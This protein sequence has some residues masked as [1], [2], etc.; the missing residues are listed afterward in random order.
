MQ[1]RRA[2]FD[3]TTSGCLGGHGGDRLRS[4]PLR[5]RATRTRGRL[6]RVG[7]RLSDQA[8][9]LTRGRDGAIYREFTTLDHARPGL[10]T[11]T[12]VP[13]LPLTG[14]ARCDMR[15]AARRSELRRRRNREG[16][17][18]DRSVYLPRGS[19]ICGSWS[20]SDRPDTERSLA[21]GGAPLHPPCRTTCNPQSI[22]RMTVV[23]DEK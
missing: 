5:G 11:L 17:L 19:R 13:V 12:T 20:A 22:S 1:Q 21:P 6:L 8:Y 9:A 2:K 18:A 16:A 3:L 7:G 15:Q 4:G 23:H 14:G 10:R